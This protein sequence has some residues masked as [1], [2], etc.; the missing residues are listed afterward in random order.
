MNKTGLN[1]E[2]TMKTVTFCK[3][4]HILCTLGSKKV[5]QKC[6]NIK[7]L[8]WHFTILNCI[9]IHNILSCRI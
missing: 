5:R 3:T 9:H 7:M 2:H 4:M 8:K 1:E 6:G